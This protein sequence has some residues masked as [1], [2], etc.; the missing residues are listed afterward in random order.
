MEREFFLKKDKQEQSW[1]DE[2]ERERDRQR[3][4]RTVMSRQ[5]SEPS[6]MLMSVLSREAAW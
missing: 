2:T 3:Q 4:R 5:L 6:S 1:I